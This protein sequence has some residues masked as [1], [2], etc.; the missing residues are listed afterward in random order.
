MPE[1]RLDQFGP[2]E[3]LIV[4]ADTIDQAR[5]YLA[6]AILSEYGERPHVGRFTISEVPNDT[7]ATEEAGLPPGLG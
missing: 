1:Y 6:V 3:H 7:S 5:I 2:D 4:Q